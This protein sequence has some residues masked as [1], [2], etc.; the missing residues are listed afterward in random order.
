MFLNFILHE[1]LRQL[2]GVDIRYVRSSDPKDAAWEAE[3]NRN[4]ERWCRD[5][6]GLRDSPYR[7]IQMMTRLKR[8]VYSNRRDRS[9]PFHYEHVLYNLPGTPSYRPDLPWV[10]KVRWDGH[11]ACEIFVYVDDGRATGHNRSICWRAICKF[12]STCSRMGVQDAARKRTCPSLTP[13][14]W[15]GTVCLTD[16]GEVVGTVSLKK[17]RKTQ[18][19]VTELKGLVE[20]AGHLGVVSR[21]RLLEIRGYLIYVVRTYPWLNPY[22]KGLHNVIDGYGD[23]RDEEGWK[24]SGPKLRERRASR[25]FR[26]NRADDDVMA[27]RRD[28]EADLGRSGENPRPARPE[29]PEEVV[30]KG[31]IFEDVKA[32]AR[33]T[34]P[35]EPPR[36]SLRSRDAIVGYLP[37]DASGAGFGAALIQSRKIIYFSGPWASDWQQQ[38]SNYREASNLV[39]RIREFIREGRIR[40][41]ELFIFT[42]N[43][44]FES[45]YYKGHSSSK[46]LSD[47]IL[48]LYI[49]A[50]EGNV[51]LHVLWVAGKRMKAWGIDGLSRGDTAEG[52]M[53]GEDPLTFIPLSVGANERSDG[54]V[55]AWMDSWL[56]AS[57]GSLGSFAW[58]GSAAPV[59]VTRENL[60]EL[61]LTQGARIWMPPPAVME[62]AMEQFNDDRLVSPHN[63]HVFAIPSLMT[64]LW[65]RRLSKAADILFTVPVGGHPGHFWATHQHEPL[66]VAI[67]FPL[68]FVDRYFGPWAVRG[69]DDI[70]HLVAELEQGF[71]YTSGKSRKPGDLPGLWRDPSRR[72][73]SLLQ[74]LL[75]WARTFPPV[76]ECLARITLQGGER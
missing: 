4:W 67:V 12:S 44:T 33:L 75:S 3:R 1:R 54:R 5:W 61:H 62:V 39:I 66:I 49:V 16:N 10:M 70:E 18:D 74:E 31:R 23:D 9:D 25:G 72:S 60:F 64:H 56:R 40:N 19:L 42:D 7:A 46:L 76:R 43:S 71:L 29:P 65:R 45:C 50:R 69:H 58:W 13:G 36:E 6:M 47:L 48:D 59:E 22:L 24:L 55:R 73:G 27:A 14:P 52:M 28:C 37:G 38:S 63:L 17:W 15:A 30:V 57:E 21:Q 8:E 20:E 51:K 53:A 34:A 26:A 35:L 11:L 32:L 68:G 41:Q 2:S